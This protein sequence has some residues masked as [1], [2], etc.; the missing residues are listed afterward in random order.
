MR[1]SV[2]L[3]AILSRWC[4]LIWATRNSSV[5][6]HQR[7]SIS[8]LCFMID[9]FLLSYFPNVK[10]E[11]L[12]QFSLMF[13][14][15]HDLFTWMSWILSFIS[16]ST[17]QC[18]LFLP[19]RLFSLL[20]LVL[21]YFRKPNSTTDSE[22]G[23]GVS[24]SWSLLCSEKEVGERGRGSQLI[25]GILKA[26]PGEKKNKPSNFL[27]FIA[28]PFEDSR[29]LAANVLDESFV[30]WALRGGFTT[31]D[32]LNGHLKEH[33]RNFCRF[34]NGYKV[35]S[36]SSK[37]LENWNAWVRR[38]LCSKKICNILFLV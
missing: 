28:I 37:R 32:S 25:A 15:V 36:Y 11:V 14:N 8:F 22:H 20:L 7:I 31:C 4:L 24:R 13:P 2:P 35:K 21:L 5:N 12:F 26:F 33:S 3:P 16:V 6:E 9:M 29:I 27:P 19:L 38:R 34:L 23:Q 17:P 10:R 30:P 1:P 18:P